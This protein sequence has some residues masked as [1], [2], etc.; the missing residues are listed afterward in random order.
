MATSILG[1]V[2]KRNGPGSWTDANTRFSGWDTRY[3]FGVITPCCIC[4]SW[5]MQL[6][7]SR[8]IGEARSLSWDS[9]SQESDQG[10]WS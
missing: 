10:F 2:L 6:E 5:E 7:F 3:L 9:S 4:E 8:T 1:M